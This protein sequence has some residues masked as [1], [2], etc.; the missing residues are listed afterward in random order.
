VG[1]FEIE[2]VR[3]AEK[4]FVTFK[5]IIRFL[6]RRTGGGRTVGEG[7]DKKRKRNPKTLD[8]T[9]RFLKRQARTQKNRKGYHKKKGEQNL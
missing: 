5:R 3:E 4:K 1:S 6:K 7:G 2:V 9:S 8:A